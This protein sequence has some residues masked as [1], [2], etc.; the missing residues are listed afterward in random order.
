[1]YTYIFFIRSISIV[2]K[3]FV[4]DESIACY[5]I[6]EKAPILIITDFLCSRQ[7]IISHTTFIILSFILLWEITYWDLSTMGSLCNNSCDEVWHNI[8]LGYSRSY[9]YLVGMPIIIIHYLSS[10][11]TDVF[12]ILLHQ[13]ACFQIFSVVSSLI[14]INTFKDF[15]AWSIHYFPHSGLFH[16]NHCRW[17]GKSF[18]GLVVLL[19]PLPSSYQVF[20]IWVKTSWFMILWDWD[21]L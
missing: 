14:L 16:H 11:F 5:L 13:E 20:P 15:F 10:T 21:W 1:M 6:I 17:C 3:L 8:S 12:V 19:F 2:W 9:H 7:D 4:L 18:F